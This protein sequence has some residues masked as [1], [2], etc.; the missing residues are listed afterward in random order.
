[1]NSLHVSFDEASRAVDPIA[2]AS[3]EPWEEVC[4]R[5]D[6]DVRRIMAVSDHEGYTALYAC[7]D[8]NNQPV[9]YLVEE[10]EALMK[11]RRKTF[12]SKLGQTQA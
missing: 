8:E 12:L 11:L 4:E 10:G 3:P 6:N 7:F 9:Y 5:F 2:S 1:M